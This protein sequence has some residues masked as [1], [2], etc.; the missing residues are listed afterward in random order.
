MMMKKE[1]GEG[2]GRRMGEV[3]EEEEEEKIITG[4]WGSY[5]SIRKAYG[6]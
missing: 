2:E 1:E 3:K 6:T 5:E 4:D